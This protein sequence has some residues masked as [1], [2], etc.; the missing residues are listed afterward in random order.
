MSKD[1]CIG[2][3][4]LL[5]VALIWF[6]IIPLYSKGAEQAVYPR[7]VSVLMAVSAIG[8]MLRKTTPQNALRLPAFD[9]QKLARS[10]YARTLM[11]VISYVLY[12]YSIEIFGFYTSSFVFCVG[13]MFFFG[14]RTLKR[15][16]VTPVILLGVTYGIVTVFLKYPLPAGL[17]F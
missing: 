10:V 13:W 6:W 1:R 16:L 8:L 11:L 14:E 2:L 7:F 17:L 5:V 3:F 9:L 15:I 12:L 4:F